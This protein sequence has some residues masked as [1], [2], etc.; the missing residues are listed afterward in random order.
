MK[1]ENSKRIA[2]PKCGN[3]FFDFPLTESQNVFAKCRKCNA[4]GTEAKT[5]KRAISNLRISVL[6]AE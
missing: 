4:K 1:Q 5:K 2:C 6:A 3:K